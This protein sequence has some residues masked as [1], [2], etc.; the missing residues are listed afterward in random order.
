MDIDILMLLIDVWILGNLYILI[1]VEGWVT[2]GVMNLLTY[3]RKQIF[4]VFIRREKGFYTE[5]LCG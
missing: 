5:F 4:C 2:L 3:E 1:G